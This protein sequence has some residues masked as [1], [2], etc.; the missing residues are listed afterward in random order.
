MR[1]RP[2]RGVN[3]V[4][5]AT[6]STP[7]HVTP[8]ATSTMSSLVTFAAILVRLQAKREGGEY[9]LSFFETIILCMIL[10]GCAGAT[11]LPAAL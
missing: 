10:A 3:I 5:K 4:W 2:C 11:Y 9:V 8:A 7:H 1:L 6:P